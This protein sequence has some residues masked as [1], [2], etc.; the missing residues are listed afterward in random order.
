LVE[1]RQYTE[2]AFS[3]LDAKMDARFDKVDTRFDRLE[4]TLAQFIK[5]Y[6]APKRGPRRR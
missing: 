1:Q 3:S 2:F 5:T 6:G 4:R